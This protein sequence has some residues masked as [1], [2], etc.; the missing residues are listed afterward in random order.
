M[1]VVGFLSRNKGFLIACAIAA[2]LGVE[3]G[4]KGTGV[5]QWLF[6]PGPTRDGKWHPVDLV[7]ARPK[8]PVRLTVQEAGAVDARLA[9]AFAGGLPKHLRISAA[10]LQVFRMGDDPG[11]GWS[12]TRGECKQVWYTEPF[13]GAVLGAMHPGTEHL[14]L[15]EVKSYDRRWRDERIRLAVFVGPD[16]RVKLAFD[17]RRIKDLGNFRAFTARVSDV[18]GLRD[19]PAREVGGGVLIVDDPGPLQ[20]PR[21]GVAGGVGIHVY[22]GTNPPEN[23]ILSLNDEGDFRVRHKFFSA[24][25]GKPVQGIDAS[26]PGPAYVVDFEPREE[27]FHPM[28]GVALRQVLLDSLGPARAA[29]ARFSTIEVRAGRGSFYGVVLDG[30]R[31]IAVNVTDPA[32]LR[33][34]EFFW[35]GPDGLK[36]I[37]T[38]TRIEEKGGTGD[39]GRSPYHLVPVAEAGTAERLIVFRRGQRGAAVAGLWPLAEWLK[40][41]EPLVDAD[42]G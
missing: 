10:H 28:S 32:H 5:V 36:E 26:E 41:M 39:A 7:G 30:A 37:K 11:C 38:V 8:G 42:P 23:G 25:L 21:A 40:K 27:G 20:R 18:A 34:Y 35:D 12:G 6:S 3:A 16:E 1:W 19:L 14:L 15:L 9:K 22:G 4:G 17:L 29:T 31:Y 33:G 2:W 24:V 13:L